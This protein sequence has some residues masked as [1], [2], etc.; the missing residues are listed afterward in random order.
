VSHGK[1]TGMKR[2]L[3]Q[4]KSENERLMALCFTTW[5]REQLLQALQHAKAQ[6]GGCESSRQKGVGML[7]RQLAHESEELIKFDFHAW[8]EFAHKERQ[9]R[10]QHENTQHY[11]LRQIES[12]GLQLESQCFMCWQREASLAKQQR[13]FDKLKSE[14]TASAKEKVQAQAVSMVA[15]KFPKELVRSCF[16]GWLTRHATEKRKGEVMKMATSQVNDRE[17]FLQIMCYLVWK[18]VMAVEAAARVKGQLEA[19]MSQNRQKVLLAMDKKAHQT[20][21]QVLQA[22][23]VG[24]FDHIR[25]V[26]K[27]KEKQA[28]SLI[29]IAK[30]QELLEFHCFAEWVREIGRVKYQALN[31]ERLES[32]E[33]E[34]HKATESLLHQFSKSDKMLTT[35]VFKEWHGV[36][37]QVKNREKNMTRAMASIAH[38]EKAALDMFFKSWVHCIM[39]LKL[40]A[41]AAKEHK[42]AKDN[43]LRRVERQWA[44]HNKSAEE[45]CLSSWRVA[46]EM[47]HK[48]ESS[49]KNSAKVAMRMV[50][51][52][53]NAL[54][55]HLF[56]EWAHDVKME[57]SASESRV[58]LEKLLK[59]EAG[60]MSSAMSKAGQLQDKISEM[61][62]FM[63]WKHITRL[64]A[65]IDA[66]IKESK[67]KAMMVIHGL[68][69]GACRVLVYLCYGKWSFYVKHS[70]LKKSI[71]DKNIANAMLQADKPKSG[72][73]CRVLVHW[74]HWQVEGKL[75]GRYDRD[76]EDFRRATM[77]K[78]AE[79]AA[80]AVQQKHQAQVTMQ[81]MF[82]HNEQ[83][84]LKVFVDVWHTYNMA[85]K[86]KDLEFQATQR[87]VMALAEASLRT[88]VLVWGLEAKTSKENEALNKKD[89]E[90][91]SHEKHSLMNLQDQNHNMAGEFLLRITIMT[92]KVVMAEAACEHVKA[93]AAKNAEGLRMHEKSL[94]SRLRCDMLAE[95]ERM[96]GGAM[97]GQPS[98]AL[99]MLAWQCVIQLER[100]EHKMK[101]ASKMSGSLT[102][103]RARQ[104]CE[105]LGRLVTRRDKGRVFTLWLLYVCVMMQYREDHKNH[106]RCHGHSRVFAIKLQ[107][108]LCKLRFFYRFLWVCFP[109]PRAIE[110]PAPS[111]RAPDFNKDPP[112]FFVR[113]VSAERRKW[114]ITYVPSN[115][116]IRR[117]EAWQDSRNTGSA[118][119]TVLRPGPETRPA[120]QRS[121]AGP[122]MI[123]DTESSPADQTTGNSELPEGVAAAPD[124]PAGDRF[125]LA[126]KASTSDQE[127]RRLFEHNRREIREGRLE[128]ESPGQRVQGWGVWMT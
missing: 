88:I 104:Q 108:R 59:D 99:L 1:R 31:R 81:H 60:H 128:R 93:A 6:A 77:Q 107:S 69:E 19:Q 29:G 32:L 78:E 22:S 65:H 121:I 126:A 34:K 61:L 105:R 10:K 110:F 11:M 25:L 109:R 42:A 48:K 84:F 75:K 79:M 103:T 63:E 100:M 36:I 51:D 112:A 54:L 127:Y 119:I 16:V 17:T 70:R 115:S 68:G 28:Q 46:V 72:L 41:T 120:E 7:A 56:S 20:D 35:H 47:E 8:R 52:H 3:Q 67:E 113:P 37:A 14:E 9:K 98:P 97:V 58:G 116:E 76:K 43:N 124:M 87:K 55:Q 123:A 66:N 117:Y 125:S 33:A 101:D 85:K 5:S 80:R 15:H 71:R 92:W 26:K 50:G 62:V 91:K 83:T 64:Q 39:V 53:D 2:A 89:L 118:P 114:P 94:A 45:M 49:K 122:A 12:A 73:L 95:A 40:E 96:N 24:W 38:M 27:A 30:S 111:V 106:M 23:L 57:K 90:R 13:T 86:R 102:V 18:N 74:Y 44:T 82:E 21:N 4:I